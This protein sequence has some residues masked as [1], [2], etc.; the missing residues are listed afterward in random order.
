VDDKLEIYFATDTDSPKMRQLEQNSNASLY[1]CIAENLKSMILFGRF[2]VLTDKLL[3]DRLWQDDF[4]QYYKNGKDDEQ[5]AVLR[6]IPVG[7]KY[8]VYKDGEPC[9]NEGNF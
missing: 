8:Y 1:Y 2:E 6:F 5:Y 9:L 3:K 4:A 7:Y